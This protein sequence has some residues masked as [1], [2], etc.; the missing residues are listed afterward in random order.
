MFADVTGRWILDARSKIGNFKGTPADEA[1]MEDRRRQA[2]SNRTSIAATTKLRVEIVR[3]KS[4]PRDH[5]LRR[6]AGHPGDCNDG[7]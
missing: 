1:E 5:F 7:T 4:T 2:V 6:E 3:R